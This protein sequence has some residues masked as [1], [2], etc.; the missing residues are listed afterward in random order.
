MPERHEE[1]LR[2][3]AGVVKWVAEKRGGLI[4]SKNG[5]DSRVQATCY[6]SCETEIAVAFRIHFYSEYGTNTT[7]NI[8]YNDSV[9]YVLLF[10]RGV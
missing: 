7:L 2:K 6:I 5:I 4:I 1:R 3:I 9:T 8:G 10:L